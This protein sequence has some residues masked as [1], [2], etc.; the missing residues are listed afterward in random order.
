MS[1]MQ[2][3]IDMLKDMSTRLARV[4]TKVG[5]TA[6]APAAAAAAPAAAAASGVHPRL[7]AY[8]AW[9][10]E[11]MKPI[12]EATAG[13]KE[14]GFKSAKKCG[15]FARKGAMALRK[16]IEAGTVCC[17]PDAI[18]FQTF[19]NELTKDVKK[20]GKGVRCK[21][22]SRNYEKQTSEMM[23][24][25]NWPYQSKVGTGQGPHA[26]LKAA[27]GSVEFY[28][29][30]C[31][32][33]YKKEESGKFHMQYC[34][35][36][37]DYII[38]LAKFVLVNQMKEKFQWK[39]DGI[40]LKDFSGGAA[41]PAKKAAAPAAPAPPAPAAAPKKKHKKKAAAPCDMG[42]L[43]ASL[44]KGGNITK[45]MKHVSNDMKVYKNKKL[46][47]SG[48]IQVTKPKPK[49]KKAKKALP[50]AKFEWAK[51][52]RAWAIENQPDGATVTCNFKS[53][54]EP[55]NLYRCQKARIVFTGKGKSIS[56]IN[57]ENTTIIVESLLCGLEVT[58]S[59]NLKIIVTGQVSMFRFDKSDGLKIYLGDKE[60]MKTAKFATSKCS[61]MNVEFPDCNPGAA[62]DDTIT[63]PIPEAYEH[64]I[65]DM[66]IKS[67]VSHLYG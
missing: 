38:S 13:L 23:D 37:K 9:L 4:E 63:K 24:V 42:A 29:N 10:E 27:I 15:N 41:A 14:A 47:K 34:A 46:R 44:Q 55:S 32:V 54:R 11:A 62:A 56:I 64:H 61:D 40:P 52:L 12:D 33:E 17:E 57:C 53:T 36:L 51:F 49:A 59:K 6:A 2:T 18:E 5:T 65:V 67:E 66:K 60:C 25:L 30:K 1:E 43:F 21:K 48:G 26:Y 28:S 35:G 39:Y 50:P 8:D 58:N 20:K 45:G 7:A 16:L 22:L 31:R 3:V 19:V